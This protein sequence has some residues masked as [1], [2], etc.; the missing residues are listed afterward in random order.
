[1]AKLQK[2]QKQ[3]QLGSNNGFGSKVPTIAGQKT[4]CRASA[5]A[6]RDERVIAGSRGKEPEIEEKRFDPGMRR[7]VRRLSIKIFEP[8]V[9]VGGAT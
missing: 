9:S 5:I 4:T 2:Y 8:D 1:M 6:A 3:R 7:G